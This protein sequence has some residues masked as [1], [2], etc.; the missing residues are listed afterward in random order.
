MPAS[1][2]LQHTFFRSLAWLFPLLPC[3]VWPSFG[4]PEHAAIVACTHKHATR[5]G[6]ESNREYGVL[7]RAND[8][9]ATTNQHPHIDL[10]QYTLKG[11]RFLHLRCEI[12]RPRR[13][14][15]FEHRQQ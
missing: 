14:F 2:P 13:E 9:R 1:P 7:M 5:K 11:I 3:P 8:T 12:Q 6:P 10:C 4:V 15:A